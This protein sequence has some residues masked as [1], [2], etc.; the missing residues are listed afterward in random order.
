MIRRFIVLFA[1]PFA[2]WLAPAAAHGYVLRAIPA[3]RSTLERPPTRLQ[4]WFSEDLEPRFSEIN[5]RD[6]S[7]AI[8]ASGSVDSQNRAL[9]ALRAPPGLADGAYIVELRPAFASDGHVIAE[10]RVF[11]VG[12]E[13]G[14]VA[15]Q[16]ADDRAIPLE[17]LWRAALN[18]ANFLIFG[19][20]LLYSAVLLPAWGNAAGGLPARVQRRLRDCLIGA[21][22]LA[23]FANLI[24]LLQQSM[25]FFNADPAQVIS[26]NL[27]E[28]VLIGS[29]FGDVWIF[30]LLLLIFSALLIFVSEYYRPLLP[31]LSNGIWRGMPWLGAL[32]IGLTMV[33]SHAAG[34]TLMPWLAITVDWLHALIAAFW[35][36]GALAL[37][38]VLPPALAPLEGERRRSALRA[39]MLRFS[40]LVTPLVAL[41]IVSGIYNA[42]NYFVTPAD[43]GSSY[44]R[45]LGIKLLMITP[46]LILGGWQHVALRPQLAERMKLAS[47]L[48]PHW[49]RAGMNRAAASGLVLR[50]EVALMAAALIAVAW[51]S[52]TP[53]PEP[54]SLPADIDA[55]QLSQTVGDFTVTAAVI[56][57]GP[58]VNTYDTVI[59]RAGAPADDVSV[60]LQLIN[61]SRGIRSQWHLAE[62]AEAGL[63]VAAGDDIDEAGGWWSLIDIVAENGA[64]TRAAAAW[65]ISDSAAIQQTRP[66]NIIHVALL[67]LL[68]A[69]LAAILRARAKGLIRAL[70]MTPASGLLA[71]GALAIS[72]GVMVFG[73][74]MIGERQRQYEATLHPPPEQVN[75][76]LPDG[77][78]L[79]RGEALYRAHCLVWQG[80][81]ADF[82]ALRNRLSSARDDFLYR[83]VRGG[84]RGLPACEGELSAEERWDIVNYFRT[85]EGR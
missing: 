85:F 81:S 27:W 46:L 49:L 60:Y 72:A 79:A 10:S 61:P 18:L 2:V 74:A 5:L 43:L 38:L 12:E 4:Y 40:R 73:A 24:A 9:L 50:L 83:V 39:V 28:V 29:R 45:S 82:R 65:Q 42:L 22:A 11:F 20:P 23:I 34:S 16:A 63:Y 67:L 41:M 68:F 26:Q 80:Q 14:G 25:V 37:T 58:G 33:T 69:L 53:V 21:V 55:P 36:G 52:A 54:A 1:L 56:P 75:T 64:V 51:L 7:G 35:L 47:A 66:P 71:L 19:A 31:R 8:I 3:D 84:W 44:G 70:N 17:A 48:L 57:G 32:L 62:Q 15:G 30:R 78:S 6:Q 76:V 77:A 59:S 13:V